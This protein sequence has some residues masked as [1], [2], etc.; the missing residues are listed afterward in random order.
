MSD[1]P[2]SIQKIQIEGTRYGSAVSEALM[3]YMGAA[4]N[5]VMD[6]ITSPVS[7]NVTGS[8][9]DSTARTGYGTNPDTLAVS[10]GAGVYTLVN[11]IPRSSTD[12]IS[13]TYTAGLTV[14]SGVTIP[15]MSPGAGKGFQVWIRPGETVSFNSG[16]GGGGD[17]YISTF[18]T[19]AVHDYPIV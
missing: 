6:F 15:V 8:G 10:S 16:V 5:K 19:V 7:H 4:I 9:S 12:S 2:S 18:S 14:P 1:I 3:Q 11:A 13:A 17:Y